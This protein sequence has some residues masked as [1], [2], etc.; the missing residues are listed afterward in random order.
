MADDLGYADVGC[1][2]RREL[3]TPNIDR[4]AATRRP[5]DPGLRQLRGLFRDA[6]R[7]DHRPLPVSPAARP[8]GAAGRQDRCRPA[9]RASDPAVAAAP[10]RLRHRTDR[11]VAPRRAARTSVRRRAATSSSTA[12]AAVPSTTTRTRMPAASHDLWDGDEPVHQAGYMTD[13]LGDRA[14][15]TIDGAA[16]R[17]QPFLLSLHFNAPHWPWEAPGDRA[18]S[19]RLRGGNLRHYD[20]GTQQT[21]YR[22]IQA[23]DLQ[24]GRVLAGARCERHRRRHHRDLHQR[25]R[26]R[27]LL[28]HLAVHRHQ[29]GTAGGR[30]ACARH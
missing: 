8:G 6:P 14:V 23:M 7:A 3:S 18:E 17:N 2:G 19:D 1:Y 5:P 13:L 21:Y 10:G 15:A 4:I 28:R 16:R 25:Q 11:Q 26:R 9:A 12:S 29:D 30:P 20:G 22:M 24:I 27:A